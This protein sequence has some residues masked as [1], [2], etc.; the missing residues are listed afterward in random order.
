MRAKH[1]KA[2]TQTGEREKSCVCP[3]LLFRWAY[4]REAAPD[5][6]T[7]RRTGQHISEL[8]DAANFSACPPPE[9]DASAWKKPQSN[10]AQCRGEGGGD[11]G[12]DDDLGTVFSFAA[13]YTVVREEGPSTDSVRGGERTMQGTF[14]RRYLPTAIISNLCEKRP[15]TL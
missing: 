10:A 9:K 1:Q 11:G 14:P 7:D 6:P 15:S 12:D 5:R 4:P 8:S 2:T 3:F 13:R